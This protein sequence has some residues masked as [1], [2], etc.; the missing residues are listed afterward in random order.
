MGIQYGYALFTM[1]PCPIWFWYRWASATFLMTVFTWATY[2]GATF[3]IDVFGKRME[4]ELEA[5]K[6]EV[7]KWQTTPEGGR[8]A[9]DREETAD[10]GNN[11]TPSSR[12]TKP[13]ANVVTLPDRNEGSTAKDESTQ[14][15]R[16]N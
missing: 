4:K 6:K 15:V 8:P 13:A 9:R 2:N 14:A 11:K 16:R 7:N 12:A 5:L 3:Y 10:G 1:L